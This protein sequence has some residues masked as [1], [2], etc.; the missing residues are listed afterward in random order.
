MTRSV[1]NDWEGLHH[2]YG[3][4]CSYWLCVTTEKIGVVDIG[5]APAKDP[6][7]VYGKCVWVSYTTVDHFLHSSYI[8]AVALG[9]VRG[10]WPLCVAA[11]GFCERRK[12]HLLVAENLLP[13]LGKQPLEWVSPR[14][15]VGPTLALE[16]LLSSWQCVLPGCVRPGQKPSKMTFV[17][18]RMHQD[19]CRDLDDWQRVCWVTT[20][21]EANDKTKQLKMYQGGKGIHMCHGVAGASAYQ[22]MLLSTLNINEAKC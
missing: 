10:E 3:L 17:D 19:V 16:G 18:S 1:W 20:E 6:A 5:F 11:C 13:P 15:P 2:H 14:L 21:K 12:I 8:C 7:H 9:F 22:G 4:S